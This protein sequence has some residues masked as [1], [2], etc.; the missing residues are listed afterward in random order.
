MKDSSICSSLFFRDTT[1]VV[2]GGERNGLGRRE[3]WPPQKREEGERTHKNRETGEP[4]LKGR[5]ENVF[6]KRDMSL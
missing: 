2:D 6:K 5:R 4:A 1:Q 3:K